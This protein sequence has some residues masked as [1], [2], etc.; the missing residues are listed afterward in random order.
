MGF[1]VKET[2][3]NS[4]WFGVIPKI[5]TVLSILMLPVI[6]PFLTA[7]DYG[8]W[9]IITSYTGIVLAISSL[10]LHVHLTNSY[11][12]YGN[13]YKIVWRR[14][15]FLITVSTII[16]SVVVVIIL[17]ATLKEIPLNKRILVSLLSAFQILLYPNI[18]IANH[19][20]TLKSNPS[21]LVLRN[22]FA[23]ICG[24]LILFVSVYY[25]RLGFLGFVL[26][27]AV[28]AIIGF[29]LF[30]KP[31][32][33]K[34]HI[35]P[36][37]EINKKRIKNWFKIAAPVIPHALGF[38]LLTSSSR[39]IMSLY[40][41]PLKDI[42]IYSNGYT[43]GDYLTII[44]TALTA[45]LVPLMQTQ[46]RSGNF[47]GYRNLYYFS[48]SIALTGIIL[49]S[50]WMPQIYNLLV[51]NIELNVAHSVASYTCFANA[52]LPLYIFMS[53]VTFIDKKTTQILWL[54]FVPS[55]LNIILN[56][57]LLPILG[58]KGA[59]ISAVIS[60]WSQALIP[61]FSQYHKNKTKMWLGNRLK[62]V[63][64]L[65]I[66]ATSLFLSNIISVESILIKLI[67]SSLLMIMFSFFLLKIVPR[68]KESIIN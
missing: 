39:I 67:S 28:T 18:L 3:L 2:L 66:L 21:P 59:I 4:I 43:V 51:R 41:I 54:V 68:L 33:I 29:I 49:F 37:V 15:F 24:I 63:G 20:Y 40:G 31:L 42:G 38:T 47:K 52:I 1:N 56:I 25:L 55:I 34:E 48:Q 22:L 7:N 65:V 30:I 32:W 13:H 14:L 10:G 6:T 16:C 9:G 44:T 17:I 27:S 26:N 62:L 46:Y 58:Y 64:L 12:E 45:S 11:Y 50:I 35:I 8:I 19:I 36:T 5:G 61:F 53:G 57:I 60:Y 23:S